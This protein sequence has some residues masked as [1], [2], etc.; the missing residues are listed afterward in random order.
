MALIVIPFTNLPPRSRGSAGAA[1]S[2][3]AAIELLPPHMPLGSG[4]KRAPLPPQAARSRSPRHQKL[5]EEG[6]SPERLSIHRGKS[7]R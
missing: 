1:A 2:R 7:D 4:P 5:E 6:S 3:P